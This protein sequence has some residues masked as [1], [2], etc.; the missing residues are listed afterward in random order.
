[1]LA[2]VVYVRTLSALTLVSCS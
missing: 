2:I 1:M